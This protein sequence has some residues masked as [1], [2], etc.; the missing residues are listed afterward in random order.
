MKCVRISSLGYLTP[1]EFAAL[2][3]NPASRDATGRGA[4]VWGPAQ[5]SVA[6]TLLRE[7]YKGYIAG[8][9]NFR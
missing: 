1:K 6:P 3:V 4:A 9:L 2:Q 7:Y 5:S 8:K